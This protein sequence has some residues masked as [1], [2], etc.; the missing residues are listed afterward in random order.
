M[1]ETIWKDLESQTGPLFNSVS[2]LEYESYMNSLIT[3]FRKH[4]VTKMIM[5]GY[6][7]L[8]LLGFQFSDFQLRSFVD[9][10]PVEL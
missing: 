1:I 2:S 9:P 6:L 3:A 5:S 8:A 7:I 10:K 4:F